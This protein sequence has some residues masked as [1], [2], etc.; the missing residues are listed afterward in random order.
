MISYRLL[1]PQTKVIIGQ[2]VFT[3]IEGTNSPNGYVTLSN[4]SNR[5]ANFPLKEVKGICTPDMLK[6]WSNMLQAA[7]ATTDDSLKSINAF[8]L[9]RDAWTEELEVFSN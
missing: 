2:G 9:A 8:E 6:K 3:V 4:H 1:L 5:I 7:K